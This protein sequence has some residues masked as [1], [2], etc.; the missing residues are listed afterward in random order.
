[1]SIFH[2]SLDVARSNMLNIGGTRGVFV[3][4]RSFS[5]IDR[6]VVVVLTRGHIER[7]VDID[8]SIIHYFVHI[9]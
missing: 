8:S 2:T 5:M 1:M 4:A 6:V 9:I 3:T 7:T